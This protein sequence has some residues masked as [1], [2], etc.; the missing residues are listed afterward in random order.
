MF[1]NKRKK[2]INSVFG[3]LEYRN[4]MYHGKTQI[5]LW[6]ITFDIKVI[7]VTNSKSKEITPKQERAYEYFLKNTKDIQKKIEE[8]LKKFVKP[9]I[10]M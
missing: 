1:I 4:L 2:I 10:Q 3:E 6:D 7:A 9:K 5:T 8:F